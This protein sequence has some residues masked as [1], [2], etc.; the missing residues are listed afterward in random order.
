VIRSP[1]PIDAV[2]P[3]LVDALH[4][5]Q[6]VVL[7]AA[8]G[9]GKTTRVPLALM[10][11]GF[12]STGLCV[13][14]EPRRVAARSAART[15]ANTLGEPVGARVGYSVRFDTKRSKD[16]Q[17]LVVTEGILT[18]RFAND[19]FLDGVSVVILDE[20]HERSVHTDLALAFLAEL[21]RARDDLRVVVMSAT[22][23][24]TALAAYLGERLQTSTKTVPVV[25]S[26]GRTFPVTVEHS[27]TTDA[28]TFLDARMDSALRK[29][30]RTNP[31]AGDVLCF[32][33]GKGEIHRTLERLQKVPLLDKRGHNVEVLALH[34][35]MTPDDEDRAILPSQHQKIILSTNIAETSL[36]IENVTVVV[37]AGMER[38]ARIDSRTDEETLE[39]QTIAKSSAIQ[40]AGRA[41]RTQPGHCVRLYSENTFAAMAASQTPEIVRAEPGRVLLDV[42]AFQP[43]DVHAFPF[44]TK[45]PAAHI[46]RGIAVLRRLDAVT[47]DWNLTA[48]GRALAQT[49]LPARAASSLRAAATFGVVGEV[50]LLLALLDRGERSLNDVDLDR[51]IDDVIAGSVSHVLRNLPHAVRKDVEQTAHALERSVADMPHAQAVSSN[52]VVHALLTGHPDRV[53]ARRAG[54]ATSA[55]M[56]GGRGVQLPSHAGPLALALSLRAPHKTTGG[57]KESVATMAL[58]LSLRDL[59]TVFPKRLLHKNGAV[60]D[61][62]RGVVLGVRRHLFDD[63]VLA[64][65]DGVAVSDDDA[66]AALAQAVIARG[67]RMSDDDKQL[68]ARLLFCNGE[69]PRGWTPRR[70]DNDTLLALLPA[71]CMGKR[72]LSDVDGTDWSLLVLQQMPFDERR[73]LDD[74]APEKVTVPTGNAIRIDYTPLLDGQAPTLSVRLQEMFGCVDTPRVGKKRTAVVLHLLS[75][76]HK[77]VQVTTD[78]ASFWKNS[79]V[80]VKK[81]LRVRYPRHSW[82][83]DPLTAPP[84]DRAKRRVY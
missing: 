50:A 14:L 69:E 36:T 79:Y 15:M 21:M 41:G 24:A 37:D 40:R 38:V 32:L 27:A 82:P 75:P 18:R 55:V 78:L 19:P 66:A 3:T 7:Q 10:D 31:P 59:E 74:T 53:C 49:P 47:A 73:I 12:T 63:V 83:D 33:P 54:H 71:A 17:I 64:E 13:V 84:T 67:I 42:L 34:G 52:A 81:E 48:T 4:K 6:A 8:P 29:L 46:D 20:F 35:G 44:F 30:W 43:G 80:D 58:T 72:R 2:L 26:E 65:K 57:G 22:L 62:S 51:V 61:D 45:P 5:S 68:D 1:L 70:I 39:L 77:P 56:V 11:A 25:T 60:F 28:D 16:T 76:G 9:A 23:D